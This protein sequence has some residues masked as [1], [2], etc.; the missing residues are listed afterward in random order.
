[1]GLFRDDFY[2]TRTS[3]GGGR[4]GW[5]KQALEVR[6]AIILVAIA[7]V[8]GSLLT[9]FVIH[10]FSKPAVSMAVPGA[11]SESSE[12]SP[13]DNRVVAAGDKVRP[14]VV[15]VLTTRKE[16][17]VLSGMSMGSGVI[18]RKESDRALIVTNNHVVEGGS[19]YEVV[20]ADGTRR[21]A[22]VLG[23]DIY[24]DL[25]VL[26]VDPAGINAVAE[27][28]DSESLKSGEWAIAIGN[29]LGL[30]FSHTTT[31][32][33]ISSPH[34]TIPVNLGTDGDVEWEMD[35]IQT[36]ASINEGNSG[37]ALVDL[38]GKVIGINSMKISET[39]VEGIGFAIPINDA[40]PILE[41]LVKDQTIKRPK[42]G[43]SSEDLQTFTSGLEILKLPDGV[44]SGI[45]VMDVADPA[46]EA[47]LL[48]RDVIY[49]LDG[50]NVGSTMELRKYLFSQKKIGDKL[51]V[52]FYREGK[53]KTVTLTLGELDS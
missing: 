42:M 16:G 43:I 33:I 1:M 32:G 53:K 5:G 26:Q 52:S 47:G 51:D 18:F 48:T 9:V 11:G 12:Q 45:I 23:K 27:F 50:H 38:N 8:F 25:A 17:N 24:S 19:T 21:D 44:K 22:K 31:F 39:G 13:Y 37:G 4:K 7:L 29:P 3:R 10:G 46:K 36:D 28:G 40:K 30:S 6:T 49:A 14:A 20:L 15:S 35:V 41:A 34:M 2:S